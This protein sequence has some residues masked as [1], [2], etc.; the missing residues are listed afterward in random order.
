M[1]RG[2]KS[3]S[4]IFIHRNCLNNDFENGMQR[5]V[6]SFAFSTW[7][8]GGGAGGA[9]GASGAG[10]SAMAEN[11]TWD[12]ESMDPYQRSMEM[13]LKYRTNVMKK[14]LGEHVY[15]YIHIYTVCIY[16]CIV[17]DHTNKIR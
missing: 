2:I 16:I 12:L 14:D 11:D 9:G 8:A 13:S 4:A 17:K 1:P 7:G 3:K 15:I 10:A 5:F 6:L